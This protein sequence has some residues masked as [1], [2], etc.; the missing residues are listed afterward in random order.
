MFDCMRMILDYASF[1]KIYQVLQVIVDDPALRNIFQIA[2]CR[3]HLS[4]PD[5]P[6]KAKPTTNKK[7]YFESSDSSDSE[8]ESPVTV[9]YP[10]Q[11]QIFRAFKEQLGASDI[12]TFTS[13]A[14]IEQRLCEKFQITEFS[15]LGQGTFLHFVQQHEST[16][17][18]VDTKFHFASSS[19]SPDIHS[20][21]IVP[22]EDLEQFILQARNRPIEQKYLEEMICYHY[23]VELFEQ[24]G[25]GSYRSVIN[26]VRQNNKPMNLSIHYECL[27]F[28]EIPLLE[29]Q[30]KSSLNK[31]ELE[32][33]ALHAIDQCLPLSNFHLDTQW[34]LRFRPRLGPLKMFLSR[35]AIQTLEIDSTTLLKL[36]S[37]STID[38]FKQS[39][40]HFDPI[41]TSGH[42]VSIL[43][44]HGSLTH[45][46]LALLANIIHTFLSSISLDHR[47]YDFLIGI[48]LRIPFLLLLSIIQRIFFEP[49]IIL[50]GSQMKVREVFWKTIDRHNPN[51]VRRFVQIGQ[52]LGFTDWSLDNIQIEPTIKIQREKPLPV[53]TPIIIVPSIVPKMKQRSF[54]CKPYDLIEQIRR[55]KFGIGLNL[56]IEGQSL[57]DQLKSLIG[58]SL[59]RL[60]KELYNTDMHFVLELIQNADDNDY[61]TQPCLIFVI[62]SKKINIYNNELGFEE[63]HI[64][65]LCDIGRST[66]GKHKQG[67]IGQKGIG[68]KSVFTVW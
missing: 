12:L 30:S 36:S 38:L 59:E 44:Q 48:F 31:R 60:S 47:L 19:N 15:Q 32:G 14:T 4:L 8:V 2:I 1:R 11:T 46:P 33:Q 49:L 54:N 21:T 22:F 45:A 61:S 64:Q 66:K 57:T 23:Q 34:N 10:D 65:A 18:A 27:M 55:E 52:Y 67:Y 3:G 5:S 43:V 53:S 56:S 26:T 25:H 6:M 17:F 9:N 7:I 41:S 35:H 58:R 16:L 39:L 29:Q 24:L 37:N 63:Q 50:E 68:F 51:A 40:Y 28:N 62:D 20:T 42:L 13:L